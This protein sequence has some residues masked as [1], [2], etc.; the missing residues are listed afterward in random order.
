RQGHQRQD[1]ERRLPRVRVGITDRAT[2]AAACEQQP[3][4]VQPQI[5]SNDEEE[6]GGEHREVASRYGG[7]VELATRDLDRPCDGVRR[8][9]EDRRPRYQE[10]AEDLQLIEH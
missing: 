1:E 9:N 6:G 3:V 7:D 8:E 2:N 4:T 5:P 10:P